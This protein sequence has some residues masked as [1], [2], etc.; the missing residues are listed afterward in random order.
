M[1]L[2]AASLGLLVAGCAFGGEA[3]APAGATPP[4][5]ASAAAPEGRAAYARHC[6]TCHQADGYGVPNMQ[7]AIKGGSWVRGEASALAL[8]VMTG[9]FNSAERKESQSHNVMPSFRQLG[10]EELAAILT[11]IRQAFG[12]GASAVTAAEVARARATLPDPVTSP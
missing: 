2:L 5:A 10:D 11:Y 3:A 9:G 7:P 1:R 8:F 4:A 6:L 12:E